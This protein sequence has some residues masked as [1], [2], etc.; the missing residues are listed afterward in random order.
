MGWREEDVLDILLAQLETLLIKYCRKNC[1]LFRE[2]TTI[3]HLILVLG[4]RHLPLLKYCRYKLSC[5]FK[6][7]CSVY[8]SYFLLLLLLLF[9][10]NVFLQIEFRSFN[11]R[12]QQLCKFLVTKYF[13]YTH[14]QKSSIRKGCFRRPG[15]RLF[16]FSD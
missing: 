11:S 15:W 13:F 5:V 16:H 8:L 3:I 1:L 6:L 7:F 2:S 4:C 10:Y 9:H 14:T 12:G